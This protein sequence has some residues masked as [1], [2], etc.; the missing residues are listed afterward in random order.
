MCTIVTKNIEQ[1]VF[2]LNSEKIDFRDF[3]LFCP[4]LR[5]NLRGKGTSEVFKNNNIKNLFPVLE[6]INHFF[7][8]FW[9]LES[10]RR[11]FDSSPPHFGVKYSNLA[12]KSSFH[13]LNLK[14]EI[15][16]K[17]KGLCKCESRFKE[18]SNLVVSY[19][20]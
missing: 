19:K 9:S 11:K 4:T 10:R 18:R 5:S 16:T 12:W 7:F 13:W 1:T 8:K 14:F 6:Y 17:T 2:G 15:S 20:K 3:K